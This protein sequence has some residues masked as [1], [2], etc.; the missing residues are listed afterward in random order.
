MTKNY[1]FF[2]D[3]GHG[4][5]AVPV[6]DLVELGIVSQITMYSYRKR[7]VAYLEEDCDAATFVNAAKA[8]GWELKIRESHTNSD[9]FIRRLP[10]FYLTIVPA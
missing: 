1:T 8:V 7:D 4:W 5:L 3:P 6:T 10:G 2:T 9:S